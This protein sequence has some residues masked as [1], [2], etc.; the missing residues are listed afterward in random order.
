MPGKMR[1]SVRSIH[2]SYTRNHIEVAEGPFILKLLYTTRE[3]EKPTYFFA[4]LRGVEAEN[5]KQEIDD[6]LRALD[7]TEKRSSR[8]AT[9]SGGQKR[10]LWVATSILDL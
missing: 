8:V 1:R 3:R 9:L 2:K 4:A 7:L 6:A 5:A 10:R